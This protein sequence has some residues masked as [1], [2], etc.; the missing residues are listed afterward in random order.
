LKSPSETA[1]WFSGCA[2]RRVHVAMKF[3]GERGGVLKIRLTA[4]A[5][6]GRANQALRRFLAETLNVPMAAVRIL[7]GQTGRTK[8]VAVAGISPA[9]IPWICARAQK[10]SR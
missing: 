10:A 4:P 5:L 8:R 1:W 7:A 3:P 2:S 6:E 9:Q